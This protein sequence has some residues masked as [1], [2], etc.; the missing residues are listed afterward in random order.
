MKKYNPETS[1]ALK[2]CIDRCREGWDTI[3]SLAAIAA[4][5]LAQHDVPV[6][7]GSFSDGS[8]LYGVQVDHPDKRIASISRAISRLNHF[9]E[10]A[11]GSVT[12]CLQLHQRG[13]EGYED[14]ES[15]VTKLR[16]QITGYLVKI[17]EGPASTVID[18]DVKE[19]I[20]FT[21]YRAV[22]SSL[23][24]ALDAFERDVAKELVASGKSVAD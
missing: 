12:A 5:N 11:V 16:E 18:D 23:G 13:H 8:R 17:D 21:E 6:D 3:E 20:K 4:Q 7:H 24:H 22:V 15:V 19:S 14:R 2:T 1:P 10:E 9:A